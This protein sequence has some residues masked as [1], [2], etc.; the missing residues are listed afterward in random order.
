M[1]RHQ[2]AKALTGRAFAERVVNRSQIVQGLS[3]VKLVPDLDG[4]AQSLLIGRRCVV[5]TLSSRNMFPTL[6]N[7]RPSIV[8]SRRPKQFASL[9]EL[10]ACGIELLF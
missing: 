8:R 4:N 7:S 1:K 10:V 3:L 2:L 9:V 6:W 5:V